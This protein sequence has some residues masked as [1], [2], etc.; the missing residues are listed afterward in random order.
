MFRWATTFDAKLRVMLLYAQQC[1][2]D[3][4]HQLGKKTRGQGNEE[5]GIGR[6]LC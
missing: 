5:M 4:L 2:A 6:I 3:L 1:T